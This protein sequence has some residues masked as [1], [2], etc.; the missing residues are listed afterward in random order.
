MLRFMPGFDSF[1][2]KC[3]VIGTL[4]RLVVLTMFSAPI[5]CEVS[6]EVTHFMQERQVRRSATETREHVTF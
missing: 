1:C 3:E 4:P 2:A 6:G 5:S